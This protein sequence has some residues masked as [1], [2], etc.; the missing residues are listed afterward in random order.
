MIT[1]AQIAVARKLLRWAPS[2]LAARAKLPI[3]VIARAEKSTGEPVI[4]ITQLGVLL[5]TLKA[6]G[7]E[8]IPQKGDSPG[9][10]LRAPSAE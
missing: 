3:S 2:T 9:V 10:L 4:S 5:R 8:F 1:G 7:V 6:A